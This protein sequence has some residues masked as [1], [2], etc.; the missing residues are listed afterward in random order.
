MN[1]AQVILEQLG[2]GK[3]LVMTGAKDLMNGGDYLSFRLPRG[4]AENGVNMVKITLE[5]ND[6][7]T[8]DFLKYSPRK[9]TIDTI[10]RVE[11]VHAPELRQVFAHNTG[12]EVSL[13][14]LRG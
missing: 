12:L 4:F 9:L 2:G 14:T 3:F 6:T 10:R 13:G 11:L 8:I 1:K 5:P 7:Y